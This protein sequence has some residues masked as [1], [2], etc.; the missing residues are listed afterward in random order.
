MDGDTSEGCRGSTRSSGIL[1]HAADAC[2]LGPADEPVGREVSQ[3]T[4]K[5]TL[6]KK[7]GK[8]VIW[9]IDF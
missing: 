3:D 4:V 5:L 1:K 9:Q 6:G 2:Y 8:L 7:C